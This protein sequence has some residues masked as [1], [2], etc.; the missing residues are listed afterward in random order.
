MKIVGC[1]FHPSWQ[2]VAVFDPETGEIAE[3]KLVNADGEAEG[4]YRELA[5]PA[6]I[7]IE[8]CGNS[9]WF[10][11]L[12][13]RTGPRGLGGRCGADSRLEPAPAEDR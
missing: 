3:L 13:E 9:Q 2:Q 1:D 5:A 6:L 7:G 8:A 10:I 4:F 12:L 11:E